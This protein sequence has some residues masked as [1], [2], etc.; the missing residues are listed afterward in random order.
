[1][2]NLKSA[3][4]LVASTSTARYGYGMEVLRQAPP[5]FIGDIS[6]TKLS[7]AASPLRKAGFDEPPSPI[8]QS[9]ASSPKSNTSSDRSFQGFGSPRSATAM[10]EERPY[11]E[12]QTLTLEDL[13]RK[14]ITPLSDVQLNDCRQIEKDL[15][16]MAIG[17][18]DNE[19]RLWNVEML[20]PRR[21]TLL[22]WSTI[23][24][25]KK[26]GFYK[27]G[28]YFMVYAVLLME[29]IELFGDDVEGLEQKV[30]AGEYY[31]KMTAA[32]ENTSL[33]NQ[34]DSELMKL[35]K[36]I[37]N[38]K[39]PFSFDAAENR[40]WLLD[41]VFLN[42]NLI[43]T[44]S[45]DKMDTLLHTAKTRSYDP[46]DMPLFDDKNYPDMSELIRPLFFEKFTMVFFI[47]CFLSVKDLVWRHETEDREEDSI[48]KLISR[49]G[50]RGYVA[51]WTSVLHLAAIHDAENIPTGFMSKKKPSDLF[52]DLFVYDDEDGK[53]PQ[54]SKTIQKLAES[55]IIQK[56]L[57]E[58]QTE[59]S[60]S[61]T[62][63]RSLLSSF[64]CGSTNSR[65][66]KANGN[67]FSLAIL[68]GA[69]RLL[70]ERSLFA[71]VEQKLTITLKEV[72]ES[73]R[74]AAKAAEAEAEKKRK[75]GR[76]GKAPD[77]DGG[78]GAESDA[79]QP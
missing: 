7:S 44:V 31:S 33:L 20:T 13:F 65:K 42:K 18:A 72:E 37:S 39:S 51:V 74:A 61:S 12:H 62:S 38:D 30:N 40:V 73:K 5:Q 26:R 55:K 67:P 52:N 29:E 45:N 22:K 68:Q 53:L 14:M 23:S 25:Y 35:L 27:Q 70:K 59:T 24:L 79:P 43:K 75:E 1:M 69:K 77:V 34:D 60:S 8:T 36:N 56:V 32:M 15:G 76:N 9:P 57:R 54:R 16:T 58:E 3:L 28:D 17:K 21:K 47:R 46:F 4:I 11:W 66:V 10:L 41:E 6:G 48:I 19:G 50:V 2:F 71:E 63:K 78:H 64:I 49:H